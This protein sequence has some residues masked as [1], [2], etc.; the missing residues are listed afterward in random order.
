VKKVTKLFLSHN[1]LCTLEGLEHFGSLTHLSLSH[2]R[3]QDIE[4]LARLKNPDNI[5][6]LAVKG[7]Y[8]DRHPDYKALIMR[9]F[10]R[11][12]E[13]DGMIVSEAV[14]ATIKEGEALRRLIMVFFYKMDQRIVKLT[15]QLESIEVKYSFSL[16]CRLMKTDSMQHWHRCMKSWKSGASL[17]ISKIQGYIHLIRNLIP[18]EIL[19]SDAEA[20]TTTTS[21][22]VGQFNPCE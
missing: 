8:I 9:Y 6:C 18:I 5:E 13:L 17:I 15:N 11:M 7:N 20:P 14:R 12:K 22:V 2:N 3:L 1:H 21:T 19:K 16:C 4:E 10:P